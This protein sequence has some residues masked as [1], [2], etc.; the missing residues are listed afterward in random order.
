[1]DVSH[2]SLVLH[3]YEHLLQITSITKLLLC[4][5]TLNSKTVFF[6]AVPRTRQALGVELLA[7]FGNVSKYET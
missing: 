3:G 5:L 6:G 7:I 1:M 2:K 4:L